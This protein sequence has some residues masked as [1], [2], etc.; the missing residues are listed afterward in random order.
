MPPRL[1][2]CNLAGSG[3]KTGFA[4]HRYSRLPN[5]PEVVCA[6]RPVRLFVPEHEA[7]VQSDVANP[8]ATEADA[9]LPLVPHLKKTPDGDP[10]NAMNFTAAAIWQLELT[11][12]DKASQLTW[13]DGETYRLRHVPSGRYLTVLNNVLA[14]DDAA[15]G[16]GPG[17]APGSPGRPPVP[18]AAAAAKEEKFF[19]ARLTYERGPRTFLRVHASEASVNPLIMNNASFFVSHTF[20]KKAQRPGSPRRTSLAAGGKR[21]KVLSRVWLRCRTIAARKAGGA[22]AAPAAAGAKPATAAKGGKKK[23]V[24]QFSSA[25]QDSAAE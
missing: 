12:P 19:L 25:R 15:G 5:G 13:S 14:K 11:R 8:I 21:E 6:G 16:G 20:P 7:F 24:V 1:F 9:K 23:I 18:N 3:P 17:G 2:E 10:D 4:L 22:G